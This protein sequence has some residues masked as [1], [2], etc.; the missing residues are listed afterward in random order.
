MIVESPRGNWVYLTPWQYR[1]LSFIFSPI[2]KKRREEMK[3]KGARARRLYLAQFNRDEVDRRLH[4][5][6]RQSLRV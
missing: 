4:E 5:I 2:S 1:L 6:A 3:E